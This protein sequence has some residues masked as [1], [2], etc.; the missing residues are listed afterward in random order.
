[1][2]CTRVCWVSRV[3]VVMQNLRSRPLSTSV[4]NL[5]LPWLHGYRP[6]A[7][8]FPPA[9][10]EKRL[11][12]CDGGIR[13]RRRQSGRK[14][15]AERPDSTDVTLFGPRYSSCWSLCLPFHIVYAHGCSGAAPF[16]TCPNSLFS[17]RCWSWMEFS[18]PSFPS[19]LS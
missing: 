2:R 5:P 8:P 10:P 18:L 17:H 7:G 13:F 11:S 19:S 14:E 12:A 15:G 4:V 3:A 1:M 9:G 6:P 16:L